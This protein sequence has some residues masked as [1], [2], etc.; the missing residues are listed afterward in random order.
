MDKD[1]SRFS[2]KTQVLGDESRGLIGDLFKKYIEI[3]DYD[4][5]G[6]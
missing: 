1:K 5:S 2:E 3:S 4:I 6:N